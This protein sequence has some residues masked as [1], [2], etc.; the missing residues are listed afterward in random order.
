METSYVVLADGIMASDYS[1]KNLNASLGKAQVNFTPAVKDLKNAYGGYKYVP[2]ENIID[3]SRPGLAEQHLTVMQFPVTDL[4]RKTVTLVTRVSHW[5]SGE[6]VQNSLEVPAE[7]ALGK[8]GALKFNQQTIGGGVTYARKIA[9]KPILGIADSDDDIDA[10]QEQPSVSGPKYSKKEISEQVTEMGK[11]F[12]RPSEAVTQ[13]PDEWEKRH[14]KNL[15]EQ[16]VKWLEEITPLS[17]DEF[18]EAMAPLLKEKGPA[19]SFVSCVDPT[20]LSVVCNRLDGTDAFNAI[21]VPLMRVAND[22]KRQDLI[23][24]VAAEAK[25]RGYV[26]NRTNGNYELPKKAEA[27]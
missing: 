16:R 23:K 3:C 7:L 24:A 19:E 26:P 27:K 6:W 10:G 4:E 12:S 21:L 18:R 1:L 15:D 17:P 5:D 13:T 20:L 25:S 22:L 2:L 11:T 14:A 8:D 9:Y